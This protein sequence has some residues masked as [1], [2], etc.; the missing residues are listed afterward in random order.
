MATTMSIPLPGA[1]RLR[2]LHPLIEG[3]G[4]CTLI[5]DLERAAVLEVPEELRF[6]VAPALETGDL[7]EDLLS[8]LVHEDL[9]TT[10]RWAQAAEAEL[11]GAGRP[12]LWSLGST[13]RLDTGIHSHVDGRSEAA[14]AAALDL[15]FR[16]S[17][18]AARVTLH[19]DWDGTFPG[20]PALERVLAEARRRSEATGQE[21]CYE[22]SLCA[23]EVTPAIACFLSAEPIHVRVLCGEFPF[24]AYGESFAPLHEDDG[25]LQAERGLSWLLRQVPER[26]T[27]HCMLG[28]D[29]RLR[30]L[31][32]WAREM[33]LKRLDAVKIGPATPAELRTFRADLAAVCDQIHAGLASRRPPLGYQPLTRV[34]VRLAG[35][36]PVAAPAGRRGAFQGDPFGWLGGGRRSA[37]DRL[38]TGLELDAEEYLG[39]DGEPESGACHAC[40]ARY[41]CAH[42]TLAPATSAG[43][44]VVPSTERCAFW[45]AEVEAAVRLYHR[46]VATDPLRVLRLLEHEVRELD[47]PGWSSKSVS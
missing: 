21:V 38:W 25:W 29:V 28:P 44:A 26:L 27:V 7:D 14:I 45:R 10:E 35:G 31:W 8:W 42:S 18:G 30:D 22:L 3:D 36:E 33:R 46:L 34:V 41:A 15:A 23:G 13:C 4:S 20:L 43:V 12:G 39:E 17:Q 24:R 11:S 37:A 1:L 5:Y 19:L 6:H 32:D 2:S 16:K 40:W 9:L 47:A